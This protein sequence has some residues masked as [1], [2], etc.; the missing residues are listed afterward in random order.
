LSPTPK[1]VQIA[2]YGWAL[3]HTRGLYQFTMT[4][5]DYYSILGV[6]RSASAEDI[7]K[8]Y[9][10]LALKYH[11]DRNP[12]NRDAESRFKEINEA[13]A[14]LSNIE[15][16]KQYDTFGAEGFQ[17]RFSQEDIFRGFDMGSIFREF[18]FGAG[19]Q[20]IF[21]NFFTGTE[22]GKGQFNSFNRPN[23]FKCQGQGFDP[24]DT[25]KRKDIYYELHLDLEDLTADRQKTISYDREGR[26]EK[27]SV[28][29]PA[30]IADGQKLRLHGKGHGGFNG[31]RAGDLYIVIRVNKHGLFRRENDDI[32]VKKEIRFSEAALGGELEVPTIYGNNLKVK[33]AP[34]TQTNS[35]LRLK[36]YGLPHMRGGGKGD[37]YVE[38][39]V[40]VP[41]ILSDKQRLAVEGIAAA[42][43]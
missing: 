40:K 9:R 29:V 2:I 32:Y 8:S 34:G 30:G 12:G 24:Y 31:S 6:S 20:N 22:G 27:I 26:T 37:A 25:E 19:S 10:K 13:Y 15:K 1:S 33:I 23:P 16:K 39:N 35:R 14:V 5:K 43:L 21:T 4:V 18:G 38:I 17:R 7:K 36:G 42:G 41:E 3:T 28:K 11:P